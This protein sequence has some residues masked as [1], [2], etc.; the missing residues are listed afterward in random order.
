MVLDASRW[1]FPWFSVRNVVHWLPA[2]KSPSFA[3]S[4]YSRHTS[5][6]GGRY[7]RIHQSEEC[8][9]VAVQIL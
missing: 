7:D 6:S 1:C 8:Y 4:E 2:E 3:C 9:P 5:Q